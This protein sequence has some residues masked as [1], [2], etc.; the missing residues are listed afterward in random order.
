MAFCRRGAVRAGA[1]VLACGAA[2]SSAP[3]HAVSVV[4]W[5]NDNART[6]LNA[7]ET[8][9]TPQAVSSG[10]FGRRFS[11][12]VDGKVYA[13]PLYLP[14]VSI[15]GKGVHNV[16]YVATE[17]DSIYAFDA[18]SAG[19]SNEGPFWHVNLAEAAGETAV[20]VAD[21]LNCPSISPELGI[22][23]TPVID[24]ATQTLYVVAMTKKDN[25]MFHRLH[26]LDAT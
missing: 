22:T 13:Q 15:P 14:S 24:P 23:G 17:H 2:L 26:A 1:R 19:G 18:D 25:M 7:A 20:S 4:T 21:V 10:R 8:I 6:G 11:H 12:P 9:L 3:A 16:V 5:H